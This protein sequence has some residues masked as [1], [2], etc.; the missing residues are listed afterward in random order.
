VYFNLCSSDFFLVQN[1]ELKNE[2]V[3]EKK[4]SSARSSRPPLVPMRQRQPP[5]GRNSN[6]LPPSGP[7]RSRFSKAPTIQNKENIPVMGTKAHPG[8]EE[9]AVG[10]ARRVSMTPV[11]RQI[12]LQPKR[13]A[14]MAILPSLSEQ[15]SSVHAGKRAS[16]LSHLQMPR[17]SIAFPG[18]PIG[19]AARAPAYVTPDGREEKIR[20]FDFG[21][22]S[23]KFSSPTM[24]DKLLKRNN[25]PSTP[26]QRVGL[27]PGPA[28][29]SK[30]CF[31][32]QKRVQISPLR[33]KPG[34]GIFNPAPR[35][36]AMVVGR[37]GNAL[38]VLNPKRRQSVI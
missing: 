27:P 32:V 12:P 26:Q 28:N 9:R 2:L 22:S 13:R 18:A 10:K 19:A 8:A 4:A 15:L 21:G 6:Y 11:M 23:S 36:K 35:D 17:S 37:A 30:L 25:V 16:R 24:M 33:A 29:A 5:Q 14:S 31:S 1:K 7:S 3:N 20:R 34:A 38:R